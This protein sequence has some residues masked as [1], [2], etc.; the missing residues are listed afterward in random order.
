MAT[1]RG[2]RVT[3][4]DPWIPGGDGQLRDLFPMPP[5]IVLFFRGLAWL[6]KHY[7]ATII[8]LIIPLILH[9]KLD[10]AWWAAFILFPILCLL[11][12]LIITT[13]W[14]WYRNPSVPLFAR[15]Y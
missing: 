5:I 9:F 11:A 7:R 2:R 10:W 15:R 8:L 3:V 13:L 12:R 6:F 14:L 1:N 4:V